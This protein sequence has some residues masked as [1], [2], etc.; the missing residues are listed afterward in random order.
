MTEAIEHDIVVRINAAH[1][2]GEECPSCGYSGTHDRNTGVSDPPFPK[3][4]DIVG[5]GDCARTIK[6]RGGEWHEVEERP[7]NPDDL[8]WDWPYKEAE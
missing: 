7:S 2:G 8:E 1:D 5:C 4:Y 6:E 3:W